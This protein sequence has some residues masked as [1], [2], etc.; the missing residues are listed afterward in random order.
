MCMMIMKGSSLWDHSKGAPV[1]ENLR[2]VNDLTV[3][4]KHVKDKIDNFFNEIERLEFK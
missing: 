1:L 3:A 2:T 4:I